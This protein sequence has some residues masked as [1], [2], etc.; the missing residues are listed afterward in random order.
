MSKTAFLVAE[1]KYDGFLEASET[2]SHNY[3]PVMKTY[4]VTF[5]KQQ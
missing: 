2:P 4:A 1:E 3:T 5:P